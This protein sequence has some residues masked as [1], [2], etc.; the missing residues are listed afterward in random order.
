MN[1][2]RRR[3][4]K[5]QS[6]LPSIHMNVWEM[7]YWGTGQCSL[8]LC[9]L[10]NVR[11]TSVG[12]IVATDNVASKHRI[13]FGLGKEDRCT[14]I[15]KKVTRFTGAKYRTS[16]RWYWI[17]SCGSTGIGNCHFMYHD[18]W[19]STVCLIRKAKRMCTN[20]TPSTQTQVD[21]PQDTNETNKNMQLSSVHKKESVDW[22]SWEAIKVIP[23][24][25]KI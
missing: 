2:R 10:A 18:V 17:W 13:E 1:Q 22:I 9:L 20:H 21:V 15:V 12:R 8:S 16:K 3:R 7:G 5:G 4:R 25:I 24:H 23:K 11:N 14:V 6:I 19:N